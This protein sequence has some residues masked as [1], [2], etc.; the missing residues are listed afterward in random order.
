MT[1]AQVKSAQDPLQAGGCC[2]LQVQWCQAWGY[3][4][5]LQYDYKRYC[6]VDTVDTVCTNACYNLSGTMGP[7]FVYK[8]AAKYN[9]EHK[10]LCGSQTARR[11][12]NTC[13]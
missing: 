1:N 9:G 4:G 13:T 12:G 11:G 2:D 6:V 7:P 3:A 8:S 5:C 10:C